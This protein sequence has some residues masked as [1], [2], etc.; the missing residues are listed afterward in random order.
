MESKKLSGYGIL[1]IVKL[2][3]TYYILI[4]LIYHRF[5]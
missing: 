2:A 4:D 1:S 3:L 5:P